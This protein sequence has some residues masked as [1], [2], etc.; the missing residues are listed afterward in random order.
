MGCNGTQPY[1]WRYFQDSKPYP[2]LPGETFDATTGRITRLDSGVARWWRG[3]KKEF[4]WNMFDL[5]YYLGSCATCILG[6]YAGFSSMVDA[7]KN[8]PNLS[9]WRCESPTG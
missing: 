2:G 3:F 1:R 5:V 6:L 7:Y 4:W 8:S 9:A